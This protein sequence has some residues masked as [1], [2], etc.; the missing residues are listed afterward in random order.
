MH[1]GPL[2]RILFCLPQHLVRDRR[3]VAF[4]E[5][6][7][8]QQIRNRIPFAP[9][10]VDVRKFSCL[11]AQIKKERRNRIRHRGRFRSQYLKVVDSLTSDLQYSRKLRR[12]TWLDFKKQNRFVVWYVIV[13][14]FLFLF[15]LVLLRIAAID[16]IRNDANCSL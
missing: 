9:A 14:P 1:D 13:E 3:G 10:E 7:V 5:C 15:R 12:I 8:L 4:T 11:V 2:V 6:N 16:S